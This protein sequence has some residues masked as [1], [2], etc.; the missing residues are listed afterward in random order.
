MPTV[1]CQPVRLTCLPLTT[2]NEVDVVESN[3]VLLLAFSELAKSDQSAP[4]R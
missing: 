4:L 3:Q 2:L 1:L